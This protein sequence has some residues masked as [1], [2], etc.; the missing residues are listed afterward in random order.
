MTPYRDIIFT[1]WTVYLNL[2]PVTAPGTV[3]SV[4]TQ[5]NYVLSNSDMFAIIPDRKQQ[6][7]VLR[8]NEQLGIITLMQ[9]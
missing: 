2:S 3:M 6:L 4:M 7:Y 8:E 9:Y 5:F 1:D